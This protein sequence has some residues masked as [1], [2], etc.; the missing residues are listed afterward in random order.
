MFFVAIMSSGSVQASEEPRVERF[1][2]LE[3]Q[4]Q[5]IFVL[6][7]FFPHKVFKLS[8]GIDDDLIDTDIPVL[9][10]VHESHE[11]FEGGGIKLKLLIAAGGDSVAVR[12]GQLL[13]NKCRLRSFDSLRC[14]LHGAD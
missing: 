10:T 1:A 11:I 4:D 7:N 6:V 12:R 14:L 9:R 2:A 8:W 3:C 5:G 13:T